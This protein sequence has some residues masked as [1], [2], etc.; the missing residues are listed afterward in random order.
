[1]RQL[2]QVMANLLTTEKFISEKTREMMYDDSTEATRDARIVWSDV[3]YSP[4]IKEHFGINEVHWHSGIGYGF[5]ATVNLPGGYIAVGTITGPGSVGT[6]YEGLK[7][8]WGAAV[9]DNFSLP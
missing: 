1:M 2:A 6:V 9:Q 7:E 3:R 8:A 4:F 5:T